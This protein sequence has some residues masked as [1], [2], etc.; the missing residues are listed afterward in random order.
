M[1]FKLDEN[2]PSEMTTLFAEAGHDA[3]TVLDELIGDANDPDIAAI[4]LSESRILVTLDADFSDIRTYPP[5]LY[6]G[7]V[8]FRLSRQTR[9]YLME[10]AASLLHQLSGTSLE[11]QLWIVEDT[12]VRI[13]E[14]PRPHLPPIAPVP[15]DKLRTR[16]T[17]CCSCHIWPKA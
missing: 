7:I 16:K 10:T 11:G 6:P 12:R 15:F 13:R 14:R 1:R 17:T 9:D 4:C 5:Q 3:V 8:V 2:L